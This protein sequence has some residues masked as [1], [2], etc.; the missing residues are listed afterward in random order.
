MFRVLDSL[1]NHDAIKECVYTP[2]QKKYLFCCLLL[3]W[4]HPHFHV[5]LVHLPNIQFHLSL[6]YKMDKVGLGLLVSTLA[7]SNPFC[8]LGAVDGP[9]D[10]HAHT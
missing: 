1:T 9:C 3:V 10:P 7:R 8:C 5:F 4:Y 6:I 2:N